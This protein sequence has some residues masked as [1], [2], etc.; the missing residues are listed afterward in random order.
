[1][2]FRDHFSGCWETVVKFAGE[3]VTY[4]DQDGSSLEVRAVL[5]STKWDLQNDSGAMFEIRSRDFVFKTSDLG[6]IPSTGD[7]II[8]E[9]V[10]Y[11]LLSDN[12]EPL[13]R[14]TDQLKQAIRVHTKDKDSVL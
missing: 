10:N 2:G 8:W 7:Y 1:M 11:Y 13:W 14:Y 6:I 12:G 9:G 4:V 5:G 3:S